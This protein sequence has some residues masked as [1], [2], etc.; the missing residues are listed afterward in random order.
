MLYFDPPVVV[1]LSLSRTD[2]ARFK[3]TAYQKSMIGLKCAYQ[4]TYFK[5]GSMKSRTQ[6]P[7]VILS[8]DISLSGVTCLPLLL[9]FCGPSTSC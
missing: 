8:K 7:Q 6:Q 5:L 4:F 3:G 1:G 2:G 9:Q